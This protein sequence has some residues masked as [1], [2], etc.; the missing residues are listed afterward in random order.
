MASTTS[1]SRTPPGPRA[2][3]SAYARINGNHDGPLR[4]GHGRR[5]RRLGALGAKVDHQ[6]M[7]HPRHRV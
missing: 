3:G 7:S 2:P 6:A 1:F 5:R 4:I